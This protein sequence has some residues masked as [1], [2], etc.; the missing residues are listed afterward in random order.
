MIAVLGKLQGK[1]PIK[2]PLGWNGGAGELA[3]DSLAKSYALHSDRLS[4]LHAD[5][6]PSMSTDV[7]SMALADDDSLHVP[8]QVFPGSD[9]RPK[10]HKPV[11]PAQT[12]ANASSTDGTP[13]RIAKRR[14][15]AAPSAAIREL[16][17]SFNSY[18]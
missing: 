5:V 15:S 14:R 2:L 1:V 16:N 4:G 9:D 11:V 3:G 17:P 8:T 7:A 10:F 18:C 12:E 13:R 6:M